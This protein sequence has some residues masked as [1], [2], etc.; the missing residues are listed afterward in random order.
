MYPDL[1]SYDKIIVMF[2]GGK[3]STACVLHLLD[4]GVP[5]E[6]IE[7][8]HHDIDGDGDQFMD[9]PVTPS[10]CDMFA[11][12]FR[13]PIYFSWR[14]GGFLREMLRDSQPTAPVVFEY[15]GAIGKACSVVGGNGPL[16]TRRKFPQVSASLSQRWC[17]AALKID[18]A[19]IALR[20]Q[21]R[22]RGKRTLVVT[23]ERAE[24]SAGRAKYKQFEPHR[25]DL[26]NGKWYQR[27]ID[28]WRPVHQWMEKDVWEIIERWNIQVHP[29]YYLG[30]GRLSCMTCIFGSPNQWASAHYVNRNSVEQIMQYEEEF[31][32]TIHRTKPVSQLIKEGTPY[33][34]LRYTKLIKWSQSL[35]YSGQVRMQ[36]GHPWML[37]EGAYGESV[38]PT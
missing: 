24:E 15:P 28:H 5:P 13:I 31:G 33:G 34:A 16:G 1:N 9:W 10:Y 11:S 8:W 20:N 32:V 21:N 2:S 35:E 27:H 23:G 26:R 30:W 36:P 37:P 19:D 29:A 18:V 7:L 6:K 14:R 12:E 3:D 17:S 4:E 38:G 25:S 22:F